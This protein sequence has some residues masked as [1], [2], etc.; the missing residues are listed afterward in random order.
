MGP[1]GHRRPYPR[2]ALHGAGPRHGS[3]SCASVEVQVRVD[4]DVDASKVESLLGQ[5]TEAGIEVGHL[6][7]Q[8]RHSGVDQHARVE[9]V[10]DVHVDRPPL[11]LDEQLGHED[12]RDGG[13]DGT[14]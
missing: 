14:R 10:D 11:A 4:D 2:R 6:R 5:R 7:V 1:V 12:R 8:L 3:C 9:M 13:G